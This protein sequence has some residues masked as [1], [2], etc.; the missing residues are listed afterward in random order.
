MAITTPYD[1]ELIELLAKL[2]VDSL[3]A[4]EDEILRLTAKRNG[5]IQAL[6]DH[7]LIKRPG[8]KA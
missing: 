7:K 6:T 1:Q 8:K 5:Y 3:G 4:D 2:A